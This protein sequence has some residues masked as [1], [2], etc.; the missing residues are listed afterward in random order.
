[1]LILIFSLILFFIMYMCKTK[2]SF[3]AMNGPAKHVYINC[4]RKNGCKSEKCRNILKS[5]S[6]KLDYVGKLSTIDNAGK[7]KKLY[8]Y[9]KYNYKKNKN[10]FYIR[11]LI[12]GTNNY[13]YKILSNKRNIVTGDIFK[14]Y[15]RKFR[16]HIPKVTYF[17]P[18]Y[19]NFNYIYELGKRYFPISYYANKYNYI[20]P[21][22]MN[23]P[24]YLVN[25]RKT[26]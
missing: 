6:K 11:V 16:A 19:R 17:N 5:Y 12:K 1:M 3:Y 8:V 20:K 25:Y 18:L 7:R 4:C 13:L 24:D 23:K 10:T 15:N 22:D 21:T 2:E 14:L 9:K 26:Y